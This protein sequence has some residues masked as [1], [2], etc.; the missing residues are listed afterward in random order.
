MGVLLLPLALV[1]II[2]SGAPVLII[3]ALYL[4]L[5]SLMLGAFIHNLKCKLLWR[6]GWGRNLIL[7]TNPSL[8]RELHYRNPI[9]PSPR[10]LAAERG[11]DL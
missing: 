2:K 8:Y 7:E 5:A 10:Q 11:I 6:T 3:G 1:L 9:G 4:L